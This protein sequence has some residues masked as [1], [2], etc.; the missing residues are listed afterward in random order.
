MGS[1]FSWEYHAPNFTTD[2]LLPSC[3]TSH[4]SETERHA[5]GGGCGP[6]FDGSCLRLIDTT[7]S[8]TR[9]ADERTNTATTSG[10]SLLPVRFRETL[11]KDK[12]RD[13]AQ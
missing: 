1:E 9:A 11:P 6:R 8:P 2:E 4:P 10:A 7:D 5:A 12:I 3:K 13:W